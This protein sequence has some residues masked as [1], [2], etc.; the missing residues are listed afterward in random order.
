MSEA[1]VPA[2]DIHPDV[3]ELAQ[4]ITDEADALVQ[5]LESMDANNWMAAADKID[6]LN[7]Q[8]QNLLLPPPPPKSTK[9]SA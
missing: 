6:A 7:S 5:G 4:K 8:L 2:S 3:L 9:S 1:P